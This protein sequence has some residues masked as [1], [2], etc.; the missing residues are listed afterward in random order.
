MDRRRPRHL[1]ERP[2]GSGRYYWQPS[3]SAKAAGFQP[4]PLGGDL[5]AAVAEA[6]RLNR[7][8]DDWRTGREGA[9][10]EVGTFRW[11]AIEFKRIGPW[12]ENAKTAKGYE[13]LIAEWLKFQEA[14]GN[15]GRHVA[16]LKGSKIREW[17][18]ELYAESEHK[19]AAMMRMLRMLL[20]FAVTEGTIPAN[21]MAGMRFRTPAAR[22]LVWT[23]AELVAFLE[24]AEAMG[25][26]SVGLAVLLAA[27]TAQR[28]GD[29]F[30]LT[31]AQIEG[32]RLRVRQGKTGRTVHV[33][34]T[35]TVREAL[36]RTRRDSLMVCPG[37]DGGMWKQKPFN[38]A[39]RAIAKE[40]GIRPELQFRDLRRTCVVWLGEAGAEIAEICAVTGHS[41]ASATKI[42]EVYLPRS[43][44]MAASGIA[45]FEAA[46]GT[47][48]N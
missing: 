22:D 13:W 27:N 44:K 20:N 14:K 37:P 1:I 16:G 18:R 28:Q 31:W 6:E 47:K 32:D 24:A 2:K 15:A 43:A 12:P 4:R 19:G 33:D 11:L 40:A 10:V 23:Q 45:K 38:D 30:R 39:F 35:A 9:G 34:L 48:S 17:S 3:R 36:E 8:W 46:R 5:A 7:Q 21:P 25:L 42:L 26:R 29:I 41:L